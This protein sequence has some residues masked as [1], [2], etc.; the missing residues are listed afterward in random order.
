VI[1]EAIRLLKPELAHFW[2]THNGAE[3]D[4]LVIK[5]GKRLGIECKRVDAPKATPSMR[6]AVSELK[7]DWLWVIYPGDKRYRL[8]EQVEAMPIAALADPSAW[9][10]PGLASQRP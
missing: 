10:V 2:A 5:D 8:A 1:D 6:T 7:L 3:L 4:L 9:T